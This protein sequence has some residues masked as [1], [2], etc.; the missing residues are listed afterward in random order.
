MVGILSAAVLTVLI[1]LGSRG[2]Y[3]FDAALIGCAVATISGHSRCNWYSHI[4]RW[5]PVKGEWIA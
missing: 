4:K 1:A 2:F 5:K 3:W